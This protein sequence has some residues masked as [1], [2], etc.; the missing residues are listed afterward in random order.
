MAGFRTTCLKARVL[1]FCLFAAASCLA[2]AAASAAQADAGVSGLWLRVPN[3]PDDAEVA[4]FEDD[5]EE[6]EYIRLLDDGALRLSIVRLPG[7]GEDIP[8]DGEILGESLRESIEETVEESG[9]DKDSV[10]ISSAKPFSDKFGYPCVGATYEID[11]GSGPT[12][13]A[14]LYVFADEYI[15]VLQVSVVK[16]IAD[17]YTERVE[18]WISNAEIVD[19][20]AGG[21]S[22][23]SD[24]GEDVPGEEQ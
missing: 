2:P 23:T 3:F 6:I 1:L 21:G 5:G 11:E 7:L 9:G 16:S 20:G 4:S 10:V 14:E 8:E 15:L 13:V 19:G 24:D 12:I 17:N 18:D 22:G